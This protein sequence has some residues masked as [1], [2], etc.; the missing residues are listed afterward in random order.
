MTVD[1]VLYTSAATLN[2]LPG[3]FHIVI[4]GTPAVTAG[5]RYTF[6]SWSDG[7]AALHAVTAPS[8]AMAL[9]ATYKLAY[10]VKAAAAGSG[11]AAITPASAD[12][13]YN[14]GTT[15]TV[16][17]SPAAGAC[18][19]GWTGLIAGTPATTVLGITKAYDLKANFA[20]GQVIVSPTTLS[21]SG[22]GGSYLMTVSAPA[23]CLWTFATPVSWIR[24]RSIPPVS[25]SARLSIAV[26]PN[27]TGAVRTAT[28]SFGPAT[29][30]VTQ[31]SK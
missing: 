13:F 10:Q 21:P 22:G 24:L 19:T 9:Q 30:T 27:N 12:T 17:A 23:G 8:T 1:G 2:W 4:A 14:P 25:G 31:R 7:G 5:T 29:V 20:P 26:E 15:L 6:Q 16:S 11:S 18:F 28:F 3:S